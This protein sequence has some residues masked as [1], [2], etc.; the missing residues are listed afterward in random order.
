MVAV[1]AAPVAA[2][3][4]EQRVVLSNIGWQTYEA[5][6]AD[7]PERRVPRLT[8]DRGELE[9]VS[10]SPEHEEDIETLKLLV[11]L[12]A[13][14]W[15]VQLKSLGSTTYRR[16][17]VRR[18]FEPDGSYYVQHEVRMRGRREIDLAADPPP[19][20][21]LEM[22]VS[23]SSLDKLG[24]YAAMGIPEVWRCRAGRVT[25]HLLTGSGYRATDRSAALPLL[26]ASDVTRGLTESRTRPRSEWLWAVVA[27]AQRH[28]AGGAPPDAESTPS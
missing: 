27:W 23:R 8:Y 2:D 6:L 13:A 11:E 19:D 3:A 17:D 28:G 18:G 15:S 10:P 26:T 12:V 5:L 4:T 1:A 16:E 9:I 22:D 24:L 14:T 21:V 20:L 25:I 7:D